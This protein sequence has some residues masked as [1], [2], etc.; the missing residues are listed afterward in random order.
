MR[1]YNE[2]EEP[3]TD[4]LLKGPKGRKDPHLEGYRNL[5]VDND[6][7]GNF[8][9]RSRNDALPVVVVLDDEQ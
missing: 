5:I 4:E 6:L 8:F 7:D 3:E 9:A 1:A 2:R